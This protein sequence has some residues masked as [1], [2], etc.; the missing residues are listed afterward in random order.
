MIVVRVAFLSEWTQETE[1]V[2]RVQR[3]G[4]NERSQNFGKTEMAR[5]CEEP[6]AFPKLGCWSMDT[7]VDFGYDG[8]S[9]R[10]TEDGEWR[11]TI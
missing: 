8:V 10:K 2:G 4:W 5:R 6:K 9:T 7:G 11:G 3:R 1:G